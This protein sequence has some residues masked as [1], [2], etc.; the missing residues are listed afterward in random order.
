VA[1]ELGCIF[2]FSIGAEAAGIVG[3]KRAWHGR[4]KSAARD[5]FFYFDFLII[6]LDEPFF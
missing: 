4:E 3:G 2:F 5:F 1:A 6:I